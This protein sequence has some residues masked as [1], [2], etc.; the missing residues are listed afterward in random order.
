MAADNKVRVTRIL[1]G[2]GALGVLDPKV[3]MVTSDGTILSIESGAA[4]CRLGRG[5]GNFVQQFYTKDL[6]ITEAHATGVW[7]W[8]TG[9][10]SITH[11]HRALWASGVTNLD[12]S[13]SYYSRPAGT[14]QSFTL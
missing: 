14:P 8:P 6:F 9:D 4:V 11:G 13:T 12:E 2:G 1:G 3:N 10:G 5:S 7:S